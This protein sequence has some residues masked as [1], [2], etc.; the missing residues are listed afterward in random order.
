MMLSLKKIYRDELLQIAIL[1][2]LLRIEPNEWSTRVPA[3]G[4]GGGHESSWEYS[5]GR[6]TLRVH[7]KS[8]VV[9]HDQRVLDEL[10]S[11]GR[12]NRVASLWQNVTAYMGLTN[13]VDNVTASTSRDSVTMPDTGQWAQEINRPNTSG[14]GHLVDFND[15]DEDSLTPE[16]SLRLVMYF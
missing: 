11:L 9:S 15:G 13:N 4:V 6:E 7:P 3:I 1:L 5:S 16:V 2:S 10:S 12:Y 14:W 8:L